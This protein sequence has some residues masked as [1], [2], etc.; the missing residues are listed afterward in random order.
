[1]EV[2]FASQMECNGCA[3]RPASAKPVGI[4]RQMAL[5]FDRRGNKRRVL[6][7]P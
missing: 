5:H 4:D 3:A 2:H 1:M 7:S 6:I